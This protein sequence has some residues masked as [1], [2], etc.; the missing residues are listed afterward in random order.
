MIT[1]K[2]KTA[3][4]DVDKPF[5]CVFPVIT[6]ISLLIKWLPWPTRQLRCLES[7]FII[8]NA[9]DPNAYSYA[10]GIYYYNR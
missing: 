8:N 2:N 6:T 7:T 3:H 9:I 5:N 4:K 1:P 10:R